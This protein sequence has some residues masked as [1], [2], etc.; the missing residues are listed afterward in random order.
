MA[1][2]ALVLVA[3]VV[4]AG[5]GGSDKSEPQSSVSLVLVD[6]AARD[7]QDARL[8]RDIRLIRAAALKAPSSTLHG[9]PALRRATTRFLDDFGRSTEV[10][11]LR[12]N[13]LIDHAAGALGGTCEQ[14]F[15]Q[16]E[17]VRPIITR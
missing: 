10:D 7:R 17:A 14:C 13:R 4:L 8:Q 6:P 1:R 2:L 11:R 3:V 5:C 16:L 12:K 9:T 15:Q